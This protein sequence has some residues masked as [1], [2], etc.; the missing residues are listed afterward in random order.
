MAAPDFAEWLAIS[1][2]KARYCRLLDSKDWD[3][4]AALFTPDF[5]LDATASGGPRIEGREAFVSSIRRSLEAAATVHHV[6]MPEITMTGD[7]ATAI[8][9]MMDHLVWPD[10]RTLT[11]YGHYHD[12]YIRVGGNWLIA[13][14]RLTRLHMAMVP[15]LDTP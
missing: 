3:G 4:W 7:E 2:L 12:R 11:G 9:P 5:L 14:S 8:W 13:E 6:H 15:P 1:E 10:G